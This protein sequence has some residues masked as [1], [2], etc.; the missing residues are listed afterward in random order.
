MG[1]L[2]NTLKI[3]GRVTCVL[4]LHVA[5]VLN[6]PEFAPAMVALGVALILSAA[7]VWRD[8]R[9]E[10][11]ILS[12][13][14][15]I[16]SAMAYLALRGD[17]FAARS[18]VIPP[19]L[20][21]AGLAYVFGRT[22]FSGRDPLISHFSRLSRGTNPEP[23]VSYTRTVTWIW[24]I[25]F[26]VFSIIAL[27]SGVYMPVKSWTWLVNIG[28]PGS[29]IVLFLGEHAFRGVKYRRFGHNSPLQTLMILVKPT[30][31]TTYGIQTDTG[32][33]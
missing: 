13:L 29:A 28:G 25:Y 19:I 5:I 18:V 30:T 3:G 20:I 2:Y 17:M 33:K 27:Y 11:F 12:T 14:V 15:V 9:C 7:I 24:T 26:V 32:E 4:A 10:I 23:L 1:W 21:N 31:W 22:L 8:S 6:H 16:F